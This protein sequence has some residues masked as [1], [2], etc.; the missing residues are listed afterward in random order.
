MIIVNDGVRTAVEQAV[1][2]D[3]RAAYEYLKEQAEE[4]RRETRSFSPLLMSNCLVRIA[5]EVLRGYH[6]KPKVANAELWV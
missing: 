5:G 6:A 3:R 1:L 2:A 4:L